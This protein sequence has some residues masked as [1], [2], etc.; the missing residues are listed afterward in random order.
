MRIAGSRAQQLLN[1]AGAV[2]AGLF[3][4]TRSFAVFAQ[5]A[6][7]QIEQTIQVGSEEHRKGLPQ[8]DPTWYPSQLFWLA[9]C[10]VVL[11]VIFSKATLPAIGGVLENRKSLVEKDIA[12]ATRMKADA[13]AAQQSYEGN[14]AHS[15]AENTRLSNEAHEAAKAKAEANANEFRARAEKEVKALEGRISKAKAEAM[16]DMET[17]AA[18]VAREAAEKIVG[19]PTDLNKAK[20]VVKSL[21]KKEAA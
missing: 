1:K 6:V 17:I 15:Q 4:L 3:C 12:D 14:L 13:E 11:Y 5:E 10:F 21:Q 20:T 19:I 9:V 7:G 8:F 16:E 18:E 2:S